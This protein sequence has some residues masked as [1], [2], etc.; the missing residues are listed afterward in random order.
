M[1]HSVTCCRAQAGNCFSFPLQWLLGPE[2]GLLAAAGTTAR[3]AIIPASGLGQRALKPF[4]LL[5]L[6]HLS[7]LGAVSSVALQVPLQP[8][9]RGAKEG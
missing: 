9:G 4:Q 5:G 6:A 3:R 1:C 2:Q 8:S 7:S